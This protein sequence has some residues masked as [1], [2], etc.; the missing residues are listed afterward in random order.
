MSHPSEPAVK[1]TDIPWQEIVEAQVLALKHGSVT[2][3]VRDSR[4][5]EVQTCVTVRL[6]TR[7]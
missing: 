3:T 5:T 1:A 4:V 6:N 7:G 2:I